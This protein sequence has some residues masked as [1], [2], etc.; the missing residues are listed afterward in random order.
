MGDGDGAGRS[1]RLVWTGGGGGEPFTASRVLLCE[2]AGKGCI[3][4]S[5]TLNGVDKGPKESP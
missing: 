5:Y 1:C 4:A 3:C 2:S